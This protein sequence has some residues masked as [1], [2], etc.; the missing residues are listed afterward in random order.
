MRLKTSQ[1]QLHNPKVYIIFIV[2]TDIE[3]N[4]KE[5]PPALEFPGYHVTSNETLNI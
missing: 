5:S 4:L 3:S 2:K 1:V